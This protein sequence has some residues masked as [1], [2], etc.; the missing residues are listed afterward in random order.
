[1]PYAI[2]DEGLVR[3]V[4]EG[5]PVGPDETYVESPVDAYSISHQRIAR[6][7]V[8]AAGN[9]P[10]NRTASGLAA[11][12]AGQSAPTLNVDSLGSLQSDLDEVQA[13]G[14]TWASREAPPPDDDAPE[15]GPP[16]P[17]AYHPDR[18]WS[19]SRQMWV[20]REELEPE[21]LTET[22]VDDN[23]EVQERPVVLDPRT[24]WEVPRLRRAATPRTPKLPLSPKRTVMENVQEGDEVEETVMVRCGSCMCGGF[25]NNRGRNY[26]WIGCRIYYT[27]H[28]NN[29]TGEIHNFPPSSRKTGE[30][31][32][33]SI[34]TPLYT[35]RMNLKR[36][37]RLQ[38]AVVKL[39]NPE[40]TEED[41]DE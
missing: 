30:I 37:K 34:V 39:V 29:D 16:P 11:Q 40:V 32:S 41:E 27:T 2:N 9:R 25:V 33:R 12:L 26:P 8:F 1:M 10:S 19:E 28:K 13:S 31:G 36:K 21:D 4:V 35:R 38:H 23:N 22:F 15:S 5:E 7:R 14:S 18:T 3:S 6:S 24:G 20:D 17:G